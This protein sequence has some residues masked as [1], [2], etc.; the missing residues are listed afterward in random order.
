MGLKDIDGIRSDMI[1]PTDPH[2]LVQAT[3]L[4][5]M[6]TL[7]VGCLFKWFAMGPADPPLPGLLVV[8]ISV[9]NSIYLS[10]KGSHEVAAW[11]LIALLFVGL[12]FVGYNAGGFTGPVVLMAP[13]IP[14]VAIFL[15]N[16]TAG[17]ITVILVVAVLTVFFALQLNGD[18][19]Q[20]GDNATGVLVGRYLALVFSG[21]VSTWIAWGFARTAQQL[22]MTNQ[23]LANTDHL[24]GIAN[25]RSLED[26]LSIE[27]NRARRYGT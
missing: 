4:V 2:T 1:A 22:L 18:I 27:V 13:L 26:T 23:A 14:L 19:A 7:M 15:I 17:C 10:H 20:G 11:V 16:A 24:T 5:L 25:R 21:L 6:V 8:A 9:A 12:I 3:N